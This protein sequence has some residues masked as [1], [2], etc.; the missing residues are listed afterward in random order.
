M[1]IVIENVQH[2]YPKMLRHLRDHGEK[3]NPRGQGTSEIIDCVMELDPHY[4]I[5]T[6][7]NRKLSTKLISMEALQLI[8]CSSWPQRTIQA[9][10]NM[11]MFAEGGAFH[12]AYGPRI[13]A[14][15]GAAISRLKSDEASRQAV[16]TIWD[17]IRDA[18]NEAQPADIP[19]TTM[20]Q[21]MIRN[22]RLVLHVTMRSNDAWWGT[23]HDWGQFSQLQL[24]MANVLGI[25][26]GKYYH[27]AVSF[28]LYDRD[29]DKI[30]TLT[31]PTKPLTRFTG[32]GLPDTSLDIMQERAKLLLAEE[33]LAPVSPDEDWHIRQQKAISQ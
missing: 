9:A 32:I 11:A 22:D 26:A 33:L 29:I 25:E 5:I 30:D 3:T 16:I 2:D 15:L 31:E 20:L 8:S 10:P 18:F 4:A 24:A 17:P 13:G 6:G 1:K 12:G 7:I 21:F 19:C 14:Q 27:H 23:P 28:H